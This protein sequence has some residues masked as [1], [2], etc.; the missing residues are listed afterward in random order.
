MEKQLPGYTTHEH[1]SVV[2]FDSSMCC[3]HL[4]LLLLSKFL[5]K[6]KQ[7]HFAVIS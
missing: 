2:S 6:K 5:V 4:S 1:G 7:E 3:Y